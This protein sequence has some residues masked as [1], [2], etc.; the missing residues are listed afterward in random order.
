MPTPHGKFERDLASANAL[1]D[2]IAPVL[3]AKQVDLAEAAQRLAEVQAEADA[4]NQA[5]A[6]ANA[7][8]DE[9]MKEHGD[10]LKERDEIG[11]IYTL[12][13]KEHAD[14]S[15]ERSDVV[16]EGIRARPDS[17][18][19]PSLKRC[20]PVVRFWCRALLTGANDASARLSLAHAGALIPLT[21][22]HSRRRPSEPIT[23]ARDSETPRLF[24]DVTRRYSEKHALACD[25]EVKAAA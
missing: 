6:D 1:L 12:T 5:I 15:K 9:L 24:C 16:L 20:A 2:E 4:A 25:A 23:R 14:Q 19:S 21:P 13:M 11:E 22:R 17:A 7:R 10:L 3:A 18:D 8:C